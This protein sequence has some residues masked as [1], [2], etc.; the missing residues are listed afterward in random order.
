MAAACVAYDDFCLR[1]DPTTPVEANLPISL[2]VATPISKR[3]QR[4]FRLSDDDLPVALIFIGAAVLAC[5]VPPQS[6]TF[7]HLRAG[8]SIWL[9]RS[10]PTTETFS[11]TFPGRSWLNHEWLS[12]LFFYAIHSI[13]GSFLLT[14]VCG[15][16]AFAALVASWRLMRAA[17][18]I[19]IALLIGLLVLTPSEWAVRPQALSLALLMLTTWLVIHDRI[20]WLPLLIA[21]W[22]NAHGVVLLGVVVAGVGAAEAILWSRHGWRRAVTIAALC[23]LAPMLTPLGW[24]YWPRVAQTVDEARLLGIHEYRSAF[25]DASSFSFWL[26]F[27]V[28]AAMVVARIRTIAAWDR[29]DRILVLAA[30]VVGAASILSIRNAPSFALLAAPAIARLT[31]EPA[32]RR[33]IPLTRG[34]YAVVTACLVVA[35]AVVAIRWRDGGVALGWRP[36]S[37]AAVNAIETCVGPMYNE[38]EDGG[39]LMWFVPRRR[40]FVDGRVEAYPIKFLQRVRSADLSGDYQSLFEDYHVACAVT[41]TG[42][43][44][45]RALQQDRTMTRRFGDD[46]WMV[47][48]SSRTSQIV[49]SSISAQAGTLDLPALRENPRSKR[50]VR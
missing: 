34:G 22:A 26:M 4:W 40:V 43:A 20:L 13:G 37:T 48:Q 5:L 46:R 27:A 38:Y 23:A 2:I 14:A 16:C 28:F 45:T 29:T 36:L 9:S 7:F 47:F 39:T 31:G 10:V 25:A 17:F 50:S 30:G 35:L 44:I 42:S 3:A 12:Q 21:A 8:E 33:S 1:G 6:D 41:R 19:R 49:M 24:E 18:E 32:A 15:A 11:H